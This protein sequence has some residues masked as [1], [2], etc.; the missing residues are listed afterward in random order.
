[1]RYALGSASVLALL[2]VVLPG[3][4]TFAD[5]QAESLT[6]ANDSTES[7]T[8]PAVDY[9]VHAHP[10]VE[11]DVI[12]RFAPWVPT[13]K[14]IERTLAAGASSVEKRYARGYFLARTVP[15][16]QGTLALL[17]ALA[18]TPG[19]LAVEL[20]YTGEGGYT[21]DD[22]IF[23]NQWHLEQASGVDINASSAW[24]LTLG[25]QDVVVAVLDSGTRFDQPELNAALAIKQ[26]EYPPNSVDDDGNGLVDD[27]RGWDFAAED[28]DPTDEHGHG[29]AVTGTIL[30]SAGNGFQVAGVAPGVRYVP[31]RILGSDN[32]GS[33]V[34][35]IDA[36][37]YAADLGYVDLINVSLINYP[38]VSLLDDA[39]SYAAARTTVIS[40]AGNSGA[41]TADSQYPGAHR[42]TISVNAT[43]RYDGLSSTASTGSTVN[44]S[45]PGVDIYTV[46]TFPPFSSSDADIWTGCSFATPIVTGISALI[47][48]YQD[49]MDRVRLESYLAKG[50]RD[51]GPPGWD[52]GYGWGRVDA[53]GALSAFLEEWVSGNDFEDGTL[54]GWTRSEP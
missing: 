14:A 31:L 34:D 3:P 47:Y 44:L 22:P 52:S 51:L 42:D 10:Y 15:L 7:E 33:T 48:S 18:R 23:G 50:S 27:W 39:L 32:S 46:S 53:H 30:G 35:L 21:P 5:A 38:V 43:D 6:G 41:G 20:N 13:A 12:V 2:L 54:G 37:F 9:Q 16:T 8:A 4:L 45:A 49:G 19:V 36:L 40:C 28:N 11:G 26:S 25:D 1:M 17:D 29:T 24:D